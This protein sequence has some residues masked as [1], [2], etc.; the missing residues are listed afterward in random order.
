MA[1][2]LHLLIDGQLIAGAGELLVI[3]LATGA[4]FAMAPRADAAQLD[5]AV[6][7]A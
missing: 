2:K 7:A 1:P 4:A 3:N 6:A 5:T